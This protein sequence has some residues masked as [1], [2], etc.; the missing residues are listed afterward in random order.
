MKKYQLPKEFAQKWIK[1]LRS[2]EYGQIRN[3]LSSGDGDYCCLGVACKII[4]ISDAEILEHNDTVI[5][6]KWAYN[7]GIPIE[8][9]GDIHG[10]FTSMN[11][12]KLLTFHEIS[13]W[14]E[15]NVDLV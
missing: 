7:K 11:D 13:D 15:A 8:L 2:G 5:C 12:E 10:V 14:I 4:G 9:D 6:D 3:K 1:A